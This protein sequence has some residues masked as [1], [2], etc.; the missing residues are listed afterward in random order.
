[1]N[2][3]RCFSERSRSRKGSRGLP[4]PL[5]SLNKACCMRKMLTI[6]GSRHIRSA[7]L[8]GDS[9]RQGSTRYYLDPTTGSLLQR[10]DQ[11]RWHR[12]LFGGLHRLDFAVDATRPVWDIIVLIMMLG[13][14]AL[15]TTG[16]SRRAPRV[17][18]CRGAVSFGSRTRDSPH[19]LA[20]ESRSRDR[21]LFTSPR[22]PCAWNLAQTARGRNS[23]CVPACC[24]CAIPNSNQRNLASQRLTLARYFLKYPTVPF[25]DQMGTQRVSNPKTAAAPAT[26]SGESSV[27]MPLGSRV[28]GRRRKVVTREPGDLPSAVVTREH[29]G[30]GVLTEPSQLLRWYVW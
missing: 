19:P 29:V 9:Q 12:W 24:R 4:R 25:G 13:G 23:G 28:P 7:C 5:I 26:V 10:V 18:R 2:R 22:I 3:Q 11:S 8:S 27:I 1:M 14:F 15:T 30:R 20:F 6:S 16:L 17:Q 21:S